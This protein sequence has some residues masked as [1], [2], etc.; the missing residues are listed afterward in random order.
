[1]TDFIMELRMRG[2]GASPLAKGGASLGSRFMPDLA[3]RIFFATRFLSLLEIIRIK[4]CSIS[5]IAFRCAVGSAVSRSRRSATSNAA[6]PTSSGATLTKATGGA[7][8]IP[9]MQRYRWESSVSLN[10]LDIYDLF[11]QGIGF[12]RLQGQ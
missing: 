11:R 8:R 6:K 3:S 12:D 5:A 2:N 9:R 10:P 4:R 7:A 1:M